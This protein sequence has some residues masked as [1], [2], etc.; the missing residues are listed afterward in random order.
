M[1]CLL[2]TRNKKFCKQTTFFIAKNQLSH[3]NAL[4]NEPYSCQGAMSRSE[5]YSIQI[6]LL[7]ERGMTREV[8]I[9]PPSTV[10][11]KHSDLS[12]EF[13][14]LNKS[15]RLLSIQLDTLEKEE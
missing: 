8:V 9:G 15:H 6:L 2:Q 3:N 5:M 7:E 4:R 12:F 13:K 14:A 11:I 1:L 10:T